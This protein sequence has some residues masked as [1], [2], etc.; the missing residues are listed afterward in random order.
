MQLGAW[1]SDERMYIS[2]TCCDVIVTFS[3]GNLSVFVVCVCVDV[4]NPDVMN[5]D[6]LW[7][8]GI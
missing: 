3:G 1:R 6:V 4:V 7:V 8:F 2:S 5:P